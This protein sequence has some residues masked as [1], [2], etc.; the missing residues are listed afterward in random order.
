MLVDLFLIFL[1]VVKEESCFLDFLMLKPIKNIKIII[2]K[3]H[4]NNLKTKIILA[5]RQTFKFGKLES[6]IKY[7]YAR[8]R[9]AYREG[10][11]IC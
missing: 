10:N 4:Y 1:S 3:H 6:L 5:S 8:I 9:V 2:N 11:H 7:R